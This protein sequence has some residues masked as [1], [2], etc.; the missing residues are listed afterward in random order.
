MRLPLGVLEGLYADPV[1]LGEVR[2]LF[3]V[4]HRSDD[5]TPA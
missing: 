1:L 3:E 5:R 4:P 2:G